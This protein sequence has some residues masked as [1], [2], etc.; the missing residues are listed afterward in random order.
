MEPDSQV[1]LRTVYDTSISAIF[2]QIFSANRFIKYEQ[3]NIVL[4]KTQ[5][6]QIQTLSGK[7]LKHT[8]SLYL[9]TCSSRGNDSILLP[10]LSKF[11]Y[12]QLILFLS[13]NEYCLYYL[14]IIHQKCGCQMNN[15]R[16]F[17][18]LV[19]TFALQTCMSKSQDVHMLHLFISALS[20]CHPCHKLLSGCISNHHQIP[21]ISTSK[22]FQTC[23]QVQSFYL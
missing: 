14:C 16:S 6:S 20:F 8:I 18:D 23:L 10:K 4:S 12:V 15:E 1:T 22:M 13:L 19:K 21:I 11:K 3:N 7:H 9:F 5:S 17:I 2:S